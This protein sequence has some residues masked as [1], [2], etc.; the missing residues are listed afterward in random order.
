M[1]KRS[2]KNTHKSFFSIK[3][4]VALLC[5]CSILFAVGVN[6]FSMYYVSRDEIRTST[7]TNLKSLATSYNKN[8]DESVDQLTRSISFLMSSGAISGFVNSGGTSDTKAIDDLVSMFISSNSA[9]EDISIIDA[10]GK[11][12]YSTNKSQ[13]GSDLSS[14]EYFKKMVS[15]GQ[16]THGDVYTSDSSGDVC[17]SIAIPLRDMQGMNPM[18]GTMPGSNTS[19]N[20]P[21]NHDTPVTEFTG[22]IITTVKV[23]SFQNILSDI[24]VGDYK[25]GYAFILD[26]SGNVIY[27]PTESLIGTKMPVKEFDSLVNYENNSGQKDIG[28][29]HYKYNNLEQY[30]AYKVN[31]KND[32]ILVVAADQSEILSSLNV[33]ASRT[34]LISIILVLILS[35]IAYFFTG[36]ITSSI[37]RITRLIN[38]T[39]ELDFSEDTSFTLLSARQDETGEMSRS[40]ERMREVLKSMILQISE[41][42]GKLTSSSDQLDR[43]AYSVND[44]ATDNSATTEELSAGMQ[45]TSSTTEQI[46]SSIEQMELKSEDITTKVQ[47]GAELSTNLM[48]RAAA[49][50][51]ST[52]QAT[53]K[54]RTIYEEIRVM[55]ADALEHSKSVEKI[56]MLS[57]TIKDIASQTSLLSLNA[58]IEA[59]RAGDAGSGFSV[60]AQE[61]GKL[62]TQSSMT[63]SHINEVVDEVYL[64]VRNISE[65]LE[66]LLGFL[67]N[68]VLS[69]YSTFLTSSESYNS[70]AS[71][72]NEAMESIHNQIESMS[73]HMT[74]ISQSISEINSMMAESA[75]GVND[76]ANSNSNIVTLTAKTQVMVQEN[77]AYADGLKAIVEKFRL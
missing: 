27:H 41:T 17:L 69:D 49:L 56:G 33:V 24:Q 39:A 14:K 70:D 23:S 5:T 26:S 44:H 21:D 48:Q 53:Q 12:L 42:S 40:I 54:T 11:V 35:I 32:L 47:L 28:I 8:L 10:K 43:I 77:K 20:S 67:G 57:N 6:F 29:L 2:K 3:R 7:E 18:D 45:E 37:K 4:K 51:I 62:A 34:L 71:T 73:Q 76:V 59:A 60:V 74:E 22:A 68:N 72:M 46:H 75:E 1:T 55:T 65:S 31:E 16:S 9:N 64:A 36:T 63:V 50:K 66:Q 13:L 61:I 15:S 30:G 25:S 19:N 38:K 58:S 52:E